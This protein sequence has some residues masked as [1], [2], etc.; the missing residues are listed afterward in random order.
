MIQK[1]CDGLVRFGPGGEREEYWKNM[2]GG[3]SLCKCCKESGVGKG[4]ETLNKLL[5]HVEA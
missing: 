1:K 2:K 3:R 4:I 5:Q